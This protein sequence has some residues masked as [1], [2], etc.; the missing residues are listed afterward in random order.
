MWALF[1][2]LFCSL[3]GRLGEQP[4]PTRET[5]RATSEALRGSSQAGA[6]GAMAE[7]IFREEELKSVW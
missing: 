4:P 2:E 6:S 7:Q 1:L 5:D 3:Q